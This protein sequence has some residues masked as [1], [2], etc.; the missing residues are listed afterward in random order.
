MN[1]YFSFA[2]AV[3]VLIVSM[4]EPLQAEG[5]Y[6]STDLG[7]N[8]GKSLNMYGHDTDR[9]SVCDEYINPAFM[10]VNSTLVGRIRIAPVRIAVRTVLGK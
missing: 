5:F 4:A 6:L 1:K 7:M 3:W 9:P 2:L 10:T 8:F